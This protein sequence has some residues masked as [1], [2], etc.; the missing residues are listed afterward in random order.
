MAFTSCSVAKKAV[1][2]K[3]AR[4]LRSKTNRFVDAN[5]QMAALTPFKEMSSSQVKLLSLT[6][7]AFY[8]EIRILKL[9]SPTTFMLVSAG[10]LQS[11]QLVGK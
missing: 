9:H 8:V 5:R 1:L 3:A 2:A 11:G 6:L 7:T 4:P 10:A